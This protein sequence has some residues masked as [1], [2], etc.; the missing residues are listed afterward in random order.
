M[1]NQNRTVPDLAQNVWNLSDNLIIPDI[2]GF[3]GTTKYFADLVT[4][5]AS[6]G[7]EGFA[8]QIVSFPLSPPSWTSYLGSEP[9]PNAF[10]FDQ[11]DYWGLALSAR[12]FSPARTRR[13]SFRF[14]LLLLPSSDL[15]PN[16]YGPQETPNLTLSALA[17]LPAENVPYPIIVAA[18]REPNAI[19]VSTNATLW[20]FTCELLPAPSLTTAP[21]SFASY[22]SI[23]L[24][25]LL[26]FPPRF[27]VW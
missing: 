11:T 5:V 4:E 22:S 17:G 21:T 16:Q 27:R 10:Y 15:F 13:R 26:L 1:A 7:A 3:L 14:S 25:L 12:E 23:L 19:V 6:K 2:S 18:E 8:T 9:V 20:E 24:L